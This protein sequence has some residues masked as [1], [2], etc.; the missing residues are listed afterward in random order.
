MLLICYLLRFLTAMLQL[1]PLK[2]FEDPFLRPFLKGAPVVLSIS[3]YK[4]A[5]V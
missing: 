2:L 3:V 5:R 4:Q 1:K